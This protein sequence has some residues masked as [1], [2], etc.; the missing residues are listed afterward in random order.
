MRSLSLVGNFERE[1]RGMGKV[2]TTAELCLGE[3]LRAVVE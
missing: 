2:S 1:M 3:P